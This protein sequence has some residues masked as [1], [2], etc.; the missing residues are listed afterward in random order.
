M[1]LNAR[2]QGGR[3]ARVAALRGWF[4]ARGT[5]TIAAAEPGRRIGSLK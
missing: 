5:S 2:L 1:K 3:R 4:G